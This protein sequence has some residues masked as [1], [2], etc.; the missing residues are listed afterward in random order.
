MNRHIDNKY[1][2][3]EVL[4]AK[5][6]MMEYKFLVETHKTNIG[7]IG[8]FFERMFGTSIYSEI[9]NDLDRKYELSYNLTLEVL[10]YTNNK[11]YIYN[12]FE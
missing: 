6:Y 5:L 2:E 11:K 10:Y 7:I 1:N 4:I 8:R 3:D 12:P 9:E